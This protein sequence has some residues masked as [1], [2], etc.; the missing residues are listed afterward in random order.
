MRLALIC[1]R[2]DVVPLRKRACSVAQVVITMKVFYRSTYCGTSGYLLLSWL[3][4]QLLATRSGGTKKR[5]LERGD[6]HHRCWT[7]LF[8]WLLARMIYL[9]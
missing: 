9:Y 6:S 8:A 7:R 5:E 2:L 3:D 1:I 4:I